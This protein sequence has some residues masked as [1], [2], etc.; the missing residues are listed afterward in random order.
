MPDDKTKVGEP[1]RSRVAAD[2]DYEVR[3]LAEKHGLSLQQALD[4]IARHGTNREKSSKKQP[5][6]SVL[7]CSGNLL[8]RAISPY[9]Y[10]LPRVLSWSRPLRGVTRS[11][12]DDHP[13][14]KANRAWLNSGLHRAGPQGHGHAELLR[15]ARAGAARSSPARLEG[16]RRSGKLGNFTQSP[17]ADIQSCD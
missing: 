3:Q 10:S 7:A 9:G 15:G 13:R 4:L 11:N 6:S 14:C 2:Q 17:T 16:L 12:R 5:K 8:T 1:D